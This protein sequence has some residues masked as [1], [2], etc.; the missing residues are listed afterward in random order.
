MKKIFRFLITW[1]LAF[2]AKKFLKK[3]RTQV[4]AIT[5]SIGKT[6]AKQAIYHVIKK[7]FKTYA[8]P[9]GFNTELGV[10][11]AILQEEQSGFSSPIRWL[12]ILKRTFS[13]KKRGFQKIILEMGADK[14]GD[15]KKL[16]KIAP[17]KI[18]V[19]TNI[20]PVHLEKGQFNDLEDIRKEKNSLIRNMAK[21]GLAIL[22]FDDP[23]VR[24]METGAVK[25]SYAV[26]NEA[27]VKGSDIKV[28][29]KN[30]QFNVTYKGETAPFNVPVIGRFQ[31]YTLLPAIAVGLKLGIML[32]DCAEILKTY[33]LPPGRMNPLEGVNQSTILDSSYNASPTSMA[34]ALELLTELKAGRKIAVLGTMNELGEACKEAHLDLGAQAAQAVDVLV[35]VGPEASTLKQGAVDANMPEDRIYT[36]FD[37]EEAGHFLKNFLQPKDLILVKGSQ[38]RVRLERLVK[39]I[40]E[41]PEQASLLLCRQDEE[42]EKI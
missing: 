10:S 8:S 3:H 11:L 24:S 35:T 14:P 40:M 1:T 29:N 4:I 18:G 7:Q 34:K 5:G 31:I 9:E 38:N 26:E 32:K 15:I 37:A 13:G 27:D 2:Q 12:K 36:F 28:G 41:K 39:I 30:L 21:D 25:M 22:N 16:T 20:N 19:I 42:W 23:F 17:P 33:P 6:S